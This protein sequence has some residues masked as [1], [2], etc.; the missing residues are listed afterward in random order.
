M[1]RDLSNYDIED[2]AFDE[3]FQQWVTKT[4]SDHHGFWEQYLEEHPYQTDKILAARMLVLELTE[5]KGNVAHSELV[6]AIWDNVRRRTETQPIKLWRRL[7]SWRVAASVTLILLGTVVAFWLP[8]F[9]KDVSKIPVSAISS[10]SKMVE[11]VNSEDKIIEIKLEDGSVV[12]LSKN[13]RL[14]YPEHFDT[15]ERIVYLDGEAFF[16]VRKN[17]KSPFLIFANKTVTK[18]IGTSFKITAYDSDTK[19]V[20]AVRTGKVSVFERSDFER[21]RQNLQIAGVVLTANQKVEFSKDGQKFNKTLVEKPHILDISLTAGFDFDNTPLAEVFA[22]LESAYGVEIIYDNEL[23]SN[24]SLKVSLA[25]ESL[26]EKLDVI[27][28]TMGMSYQTVDAKI[29]IEKKNP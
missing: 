5:N 13:S 22:K 29:I 2:F 10:E 25:D 1:F 15:T 14:T 16:D 17:P 21:N 12:S 7:A 26:F 19:V 11:K 9:N 24:R 6:D 3:S 4:D 27:C 20:V 8:R 18:V 28:Q 23:V